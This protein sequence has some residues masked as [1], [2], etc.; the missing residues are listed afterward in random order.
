M[1]QLRLRLHQSTDLFEALINTSQHF[2]FK[3]SKSF[4]LFIYFSYNTIHPTPLQMP[5]AYY[6]SLHLRLF[7]NY[8]RNNYGK[9]TINIFN[10]KMHWMISDVGCEAGQSVKLKIH[11]RSCC[12]HY[13]QLFDDFAVPTHALGHV[14]VQFQIYTSDIDKLKTQ[15]GFGVDILQRPEG[16]SLDT[17]G[18]FLIILNDAF[19]C[20]Y[21]NSLNG[22]SYSIHSQTKPPKQKI[23]F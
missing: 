9:F 2:T 17:N 14:R 22:N 6:K 8:G 21:R 16:S 7:I 20:I 1:R 18:F 15:W 11:R 3:K 12:T 4:S 23:I 10:V 5:M 19:N 13:Y